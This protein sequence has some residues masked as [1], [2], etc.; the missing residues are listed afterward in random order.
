MSHFIASNDLSDTVQ[1]VDSS[2]GFFSK[3]PFHKAKLH[4]YNRDMIDSGKKNEYPFD[5]AQCLIVLPLRPNQFFVERPPSVR[6]FISPAIAEFNAKIINYNGDIIAELIDK[7]TGEVK[8]VHPPSKKDSSGNLILVSNEYN[9]S[10]KKV[11]FI[12]SH[13]FVF[14][15]KPSGAF[16]TR[17]ETRNVLKRMD[18]NL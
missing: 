5:Q 4:Q 7:S 8:Y 12:D 2:H 6:K 3:Y 17:D 11:M 18:K 16:L 15:K 10:L 9:V 1:G 13:Y 14:T